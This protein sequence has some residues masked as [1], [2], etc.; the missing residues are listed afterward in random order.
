MS[1]AIG[2]RGAALEP[3]PST[4]VI[5]GREVRLPVEVRDATAAIAY[6]LVPSEA[7]QRLIRAPALLVARVLPGRTLCT[8][9][10]MDYKD[11]DLGQYHEIA[12][13]FFVH[14]RRAQPLP[15]IGTA[16]RLLRGG[17]DAYIQ[18][19][20]VDGEFTCEAGR[21]IW[22]FPKFM[23]EIALSTDSET[24]TSVLRAGG[25]EVL[26]QTVRTGGARG[27]S[28]RPQVSY[29]YRDGVLYKT[30]AVVSAEGMG[31]RLGGAH[32]ELGAHPLADELRSLG[33]PRRPLFTMYVSKMTGRFYAAERR[34]MSPP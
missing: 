10:T 5:M 24:Q 25:Q 30:L 32:L 9:G 14:E 19:L 2:A 27:F 20:P 23:T 31:A 28:E 22:G 26:R 3:S 34:Q 33:L 29:A 18:W 12:V 15:F 7:A 8:I 13:T 17:I 4:Y 16:L 6:Y 11:S 21:T 1:P